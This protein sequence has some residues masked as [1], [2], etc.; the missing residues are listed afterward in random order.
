M[1][2]LERDEGLEGRGA[3]ERPRRWVCRCSEPPVLLATLEGNRIN[4]KIRDR[5]YH[6]EALRGRIQATCPLCGKQHTIT[7]GGEA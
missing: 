6:I 7:F 3:G 5:Y 4:L 1:R 2:R